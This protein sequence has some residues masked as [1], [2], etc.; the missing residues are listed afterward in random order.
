[1][2]SSAPRPIL[3]AR[4]PTGYHQLFC[5]GIYSCSSLSLVLILALVTSV[6]ST[7]RSSCGR[8]AS[9]SQLGLC[10]G[11]Q[12]ACP[13]SLP[14]WFPRVSSW[15]S[16]PREA[17][18]LQSQRTTTISVTPFGFGFGCIFPQK[19]L[20]FCL[21]RGGEG[22]KSTMAERSPWAC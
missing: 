3:P 2:G 13:H 16:L 17:L 10:P 12:D 5:P 22:Y 14:L 19:L 6:L 8:S 9:S 4:P 18:V 21:P 7:G 20:F 11:V 1:M 15:P